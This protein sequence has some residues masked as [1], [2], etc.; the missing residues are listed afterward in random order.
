[1][2]VIAISKNLIEH[3]DFAVDVIISV[4]YILVVC[5][6]VIQEVVNNEQAEISYI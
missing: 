1:M 5:P 2:F 3:Q 4:K 6:Q